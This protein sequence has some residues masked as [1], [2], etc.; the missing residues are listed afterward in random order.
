MLVKGAVLMVVMRGE[1][2]GAKK[3]VST[4]DSKVDK[5]QALMVEMRV[6]MMVA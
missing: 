6:E 3:V 5:R 2:R 1:T 4:A